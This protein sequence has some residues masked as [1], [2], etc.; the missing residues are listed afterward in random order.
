[1]TIHT[2]GDSTLD[3]LFWM[4][5]AKGDLQLAKK[6]T[7]EGYLHDVVSH[8]YDGFTTHSVL[9]GGRIGAVLCPSLAKKLYLQE[10]ATHGLFVRPLETL[11]KAIASNSNTH[12]YVVISIGGNDFREKLGNPI[13]LLREIPHIQKRYLQILR[14]VKAPNVYP[15]LMLQYRTDINHDPYH[16]YTI[17]KIIGLFAMTIHLLSLSLLTAPLWALAGKISAFAATLLFL[18]GA[19][20]L[21]FS[22]KTIPLS[23]T[24]QIL[25]GKKISLSVL[26]SLIHSFY[27]PILEKAKEERIP[28]LDLPNTFDPNQ[29]L[30][31]CG[32][33][34]GEKGG[35]LIAEGIHHIIKHHDFTGE[36]KL[37][38]KEKE[39]YEGVPNRNPAIWKVKN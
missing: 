23:V 33:E 28:I 29:D 31:E 12:H 35:K 38:S 27:Q 25:L 36:S 3:N 26:A 13:H 39:T 14:K 5:Q 19:T 18:A 34:P 10:K 30:Y 15:I 37:Y 32:I 7:V 24:K 1:M 2:L 20:G 8:A 6:C 9:Q 17:F 11:H 21:Y 22:H 4:I 16:I